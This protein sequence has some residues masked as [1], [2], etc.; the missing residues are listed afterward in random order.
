MSIEKFILTIEDPA[1][2]RY[3]LAASGPYP[4]KLAFKMDETVQNIVKFGL[5]AQEIKQRAN[6]G[7]LVLRRIQDRG[8]KEIDDISMACFCYI[9]EAIGYKEAVPELGN[10][11]SEMYKIKKRGEMAFTLYFAVNAIKVLTKQPG[12]R[13]DLAYSD[14]EIEETIKRTESPMRE[15]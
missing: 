14:K 15:G 6:V 12:L 4:L 7:N 8:R 11:L 9:L 5:A 13:E 2:I 1:K 3:A 10:L